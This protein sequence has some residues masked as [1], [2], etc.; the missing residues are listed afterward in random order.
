MTLSPAKI[1]ALEDGTVIRVLTTFTEVIL[2][3]GHLVS[4]VPQN[5]AEQRATAAGLGYP[6]GDDG[7]AMVLHHDP[8]HALLCCWLG[9]PSRALQVAAG[10]LPEYDEMACLEEDAVLAVQRLMVRAGGTLPGRWNTL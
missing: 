10:L 4:G 9:I 5:S 3:S 2:P 1:C 8:L 6:S 7:L